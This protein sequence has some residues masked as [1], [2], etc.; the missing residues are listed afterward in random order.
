[1]KAEDRGA[2]LGTHFFFTNRLS[3]M[4]HAPLPGSDTVSLPH[5]CASDAPA[6]LKAV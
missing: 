6:L 2:G 3:T 4:D 5:R 1:M